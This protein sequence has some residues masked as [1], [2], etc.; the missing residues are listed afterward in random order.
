MKVIRIEYASKSNSW[1]NGLYVVVNKTRT[2][3]KLCKLDSDMNPVTYEDGT[4]DISIIGCVN[5][6][7]IKETGMTYSRIEYNNKVRNEGNKDTGKSTG[8]RP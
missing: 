1:N 8:R 4:P 7:N 2:Q 5:N 6:E 3:Y